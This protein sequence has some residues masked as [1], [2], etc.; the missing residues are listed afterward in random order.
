M[1]IEFQ[2]CP[3]CLGVGGYLQVHPI[4]GSNYASSW[5]QWYTCGQCGGRGHIQILM[6]DPY[7]PPQS[8]AIG[9]W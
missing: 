7:Y 4:A 8:I 9:E 6:E 5:N 3:S 1:I 2:V